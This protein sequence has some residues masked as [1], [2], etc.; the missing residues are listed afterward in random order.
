MN[1][2]GPKIGPWGTPAFMLTQVEDPPGKTTLCLQT[3][4]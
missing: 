3:L 2:S 4:K 1:K